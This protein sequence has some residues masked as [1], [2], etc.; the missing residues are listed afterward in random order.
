MGG[1][2]RALSGS[3]DQKWR[4]RKPMRAAPEVIRQALIVA[5]LWLLCGPVSAAYYSYQGTLE[6]QGTFG[7]GCQ[8]LEPRQ[9]VT[10]TL[11][12]GGAGG[13]LEGYLSLTNLNAV[14]RFRGSTLAQLSVEL[15]LD[16]SAQPPSYQMALQGNPD[17]LSGGQVQG[18]GN[19][20]GPACFIRAGKLTLAPTPANPAQPAQHRFEQDGAMFG[21]VLQANA[22]NALTLQ[23]RYP[24]A[25]SKLQSARD[26]AEAAFSIENPL[27]VAQITA[28][29]AAAQEA[30]GD[31]AAAAG[32]YQQAL[33]D[34]EK[35]A[36]ADAPGD[37]PLLQ[38]LGHVLERQHH[39]VDA[40]PLYRR[41]IAI[42]GKLA[43]TAG[44][45]YGNSL[46]PLGALLMT[47]GRYLEAEPL[48]RQILDI[49]ERI[50]GANDQ[51]TAS[52]A[53]NLANPLVL[54]GKYTEA[55]A[56]YQRALAINERDFGPDS[57]AVGINVFNLA[58]LYQQAGRYEE[59]EAL[60]HRA[61]AMAEHIEGAQS[62][63]VATVLV[64]LA[65]NLKDTEHY[66]EA[67]PLYRRALALHE[68]ILGPAQPA[69][70][71]DLH[72]LGLLLYSA[73]R[74]G[75][76]EPL[77][78][79]ALSIDEQALG[80]DTPVVA[81]ILNDLAWLLRYTGRLNEAESASRRA[82]AVA[83]QALGPEHPQVATNLV[84][85]AGLMLITQRYAEAESL[86]KRAL[87][88]REKSFGADSGV[89]AVTLNNLSNVYQ[90]TKRYAEA[91]PLLRRALAIN[92]HVHGLDSTSS[93]WN[94]DNLGGLL[95]NTGR[96]EEGLPLM[97]HAY[98]IA[99]SNAVAPLVW[100]SPNRLMDFYSAGGP[101]GAPLAIYYGK[102]AVNTLQHMRGN[103]GGAS[104]DTQ[105]SFVDSVA[106]IY[107]RLA[108][109]LVEAGRL[110]EAQ[111]ILAMLKEQELYNY[112][113]RS[114]DTDV[115]S[116]T[117]SLTPAEQQLEASS[118]HWISLSKEYAALQQRFGAEGEPFK[119]TPGYARMIRL[120][121]LVDAA[122]ASYDAAET[123][124]ARETSADRAQR[125]KDFGVDFQDTLRELGHGAAL[126]QY[127]IL[128][129]KVEILVTTPEISLAEEAPIKRAELN[130]MINAFRQTLISRAD[131]L[132]QAQA[133]YRLLIGP[134]EKDLNENGTQTLMLSLDDTLRYLPFA[135][136]HDG[137]GYLIER[138]AL[139]LVTEA[140]R[141]HLV[142]RAANNNWTIWGLGVT[143][144]H[145]EGPD[146][147]PALPMVGA[148][149][150]A[151]AGPN[152]ILTGELMLDPAF[153]ANALR[154][155]LE[156]SFPIVHIASH[157]KFNPAN[158]DDSYLLLG[159]GSHLSLKQIGKMN[160]KKVELLTLSACETALGGPGSDSHG[161]E[162]ESLG[163]IAQQQGARAVLATL[164]PVADTSTALLMRTL[165]QEH[166]QQL[167][168]AEALRQ[169]QLALLH[170]TIQV[171]SLPDTVRSAINLAGPTKIAATAAAPV[172]PKAPYA[173]PYFWAPFILMGSWQ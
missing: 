79:R 19:Y 53:N 120:R 6:I 147:F 26:A 159:D 69:V 72:L 119:T 126:A 127:F 67:E 140:A 49:D 25:I 86:D 20:D 27:I 76:C 94:L 28:L 1:E 33:A 24:E 143:R 144:S 149:L 156:R 56:L 3:L 71:D 104:N 78:R 42:T 146:K 138:Y 91:E 92:Q 168:K 148:E 121:P 58:L 160:F 75:E 151:I 61:Q 130:R 128:D 68:Q 166:Q 30:G 123:L 125:V 163:A 40:E 81:A 73:G 105:S 39:G 113:E 82:L 111:Q 15:S 131:P 108:N 8:G 165:Y 133:L 47:E 2:F 11:N 107:R 158:A 145:D 63:A 116:T 85:L 44:V 171:S 77:L 23:K 55:E 70:A 109:L 74:Y 84:T 35:L 136:L 59:A 170:G 134:I 101:E 90:A 18:S 52:A 110:G 46:A 31:L 95:S 129:D 54:L 65:N 88:I 102:V 97:L 17:S 157:F 83:E 14:Q 172:D 22:A 103:L 60:L 50:Y 87:A 137:H 106:P 41:A 4:V 51:H 150:S 141:N 89:V 10:L 153:D 29:Q 34:T 169:A 98:R 5:A 173:H 164:W 62:S 99:R 152:G 64:A 13:A 124:I 36:G 37:V 100:S 161:A 154:E 114:A 38:Q 142:D 48:L 135:A 80:H 45:V 155:G 12:D 112:T 66:A 115:R 21:I 16:A 32:T 96:R 117:A 43:G 93:G 57:A 118:D 132:P 122:Q 7:H 162:V 9:P 167:D 139:A